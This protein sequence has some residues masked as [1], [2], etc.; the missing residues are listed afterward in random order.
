VT[1]FVLFIYK[2]TNEL[3]TLLHVQ[4]I[5]HIFYT[6]NTKLRSTNTGNVIDY[7]LVALIYLH[8]PALNNELCLHFVTIFLQMA[9]I[10][11]IVLST[12]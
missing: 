9:Q 10:D 8:S 2:Y 1:L 11:C 3:N 12:D 4:L 6:F 7:L 5:L